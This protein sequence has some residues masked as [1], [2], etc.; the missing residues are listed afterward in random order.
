MRL[1]SLPIIFAL[2]GCALGSSALKPLGTLVGSPVQSVFSAIGYPDRQEIVA[3]NTVYHWGV[4]Q[5]G[6][7]PNDADGTMSDAAQLGSLGGKNRAANMTPR[8]RK[9]IAQKAAA[10]QRSKLLSDRFATQDNSFKVANLQGGH[11]LPTRWC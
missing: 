11:C 4:D 1:L 6:D 10:T 2:S 8:R 3:G 7:G 5:P 9:E